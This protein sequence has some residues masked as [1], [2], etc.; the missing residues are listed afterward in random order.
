LNYLFNGG[1]ALNARLFESIIDFG[2]QHEV[3]RIAITVDKVFQATAASL[4]CS[5]QGIFNG[6]RQHR[7]PWLR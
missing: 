3:P 2:L 4:D 1:F 6:Q 7:R 5:A